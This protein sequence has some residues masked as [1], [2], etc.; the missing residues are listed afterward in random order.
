[1]TCESCHAGAA[2][3]AVDLDDM[4]GLHSF[5]VSQG[6]GCQDCHQSTTADGL[7][8]SMPSLHIN[9]QRDLQ[10]TAPGFS[11]DQGTQGC[12]GTCHGYPHIARPWLGSGGDFHPPGFANPDV[13]SPEMHSS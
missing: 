1:M 3:P 7:T 5:H 2:S 11:Y 8:I 12:S 6:A 10:F 9:A 13:H 4:S